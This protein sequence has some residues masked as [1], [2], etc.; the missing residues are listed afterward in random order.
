MLI[1]WLS[2]I[3]EDGFYLW[4]YTVSTPI[5]HEIVDKTFLADV[6]TTY[7]DRVSAVADPDNKRNNADQ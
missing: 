5:G 4:D 2:A 3:A 7:F 1:S 6:D